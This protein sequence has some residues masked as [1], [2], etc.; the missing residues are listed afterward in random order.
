MAEW[1]NNR[2][3]EADVI[4][5]SRVRLA[6]NLTNYPFPVRMSQDQQQQ[7]VQ[8]VVEV[9]QE[10]EDIKYF[11]YDINKMDNISKLE[12]VEKHLISP[13]MAM[14]SRE[15]ALVLS[16]DNKTSVMINEED[17]IR[18][19]CILP[20]M[21]LEEAW[22]QC[23]ELDTELEKKLTYTFDAESGYLTCCPSNIGTGIRASVMM[24][25]PALTM[26]GY[27]GK[28]L[29]AC[30]KLGVAVRGLFGENSEASGCMYQ[31]SNQVTLGQ[32][33]EEILHGVI[34]VASQIINQE[35]MLRGELYKQ[36]S[37]RFDDKVFRAYGILKNSRILSAEEAMKLL[38][39]V[40]LGVDMDIIKS[41]DTNILNELMVA[42][43]PASLHKAFRQEFTPEQRD[44]KRAELLR[45]K[46]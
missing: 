5:S 25:L 12:L 43:Q 35:R 8:K 20:G 18:L 38:S 10:K 3:P 19:Q 29:E 42:V 31:V 34:N 9:L 40:R 21:Q 39:D 24:H 45:N 46:L 17:H 11:A 13:D 33:E 36:N 41:V 1:Y 2:G 37:Y 16:E 32:S 27:I 15:R 6:R 23:D 7:V 30:A 14:G 22:K 26:T 44:I 28:I 4:I